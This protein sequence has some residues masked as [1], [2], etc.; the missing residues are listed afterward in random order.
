MHMITCE[1]PESSCSH[2][3]DQPQVP[4]A[5]PGS[6]M[7]QGQV[8]TAR[9]PLSESTWINRDRLDTFRSLN[10][11]NGRHLTANDERSQLRNTLLIGAVHDQPTTTVR[12]SLVLGCW[13]HPTAYRGRI[14]RRGGGARRGVGRGDRPCRRAPGTGT[15]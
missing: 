1:L 6:K 5:G 2:A 11:A 9:R 7:A 3:P 15:L 8:L 14:W 12:E 4:P 10:C 13:T